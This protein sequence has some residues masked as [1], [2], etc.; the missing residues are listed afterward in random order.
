MLDPK[1]CFPYHS[2]R[3][4]GVFWLKLHHPHHCLVPSVEYTP[5]EG[6]PKYLVVRTLDKNLF[7]NFIYTRY[8][9]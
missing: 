4:Y 8:L 9:L 1:I 6:V 5:I 3:Q 2:Q 7:L